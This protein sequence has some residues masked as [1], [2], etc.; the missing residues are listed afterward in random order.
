MVSLGVYLSSSIP[1]AA[2]IYD[3]NCVFFSACVIGSNR[4]EGEISRS[5]YV[6]V[7]TER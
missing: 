6:E 1:P 2:L 7:S 3:L 4:K 5:G